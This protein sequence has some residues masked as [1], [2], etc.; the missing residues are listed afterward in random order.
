MR[1]PGWARCFNC[2]PPVIP[3][4]HPSFPRSLS[5]TP[6]PTPTPIGERESIPPRTRLSREACPRPRSG[7]R[8]SIPPHTRLSRESGNPYVLNVGL[9][10]DKPK[11]HGKTGVVAK[12]KGRWLAGEG[13][14][15]LRCAEPL[16]R[17]RP[18]RLG[19]VVVSELRLSAG[20]QSRFNEAVLLCNSQAWQAKL[21]GLWLWGV[22][23]PLFH[24]IAW[25]RARSGRRGNQEQRI[26]IALDS[27]PTRF[28]WVCLAGP[29]G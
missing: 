22:R 10:L 13:L 19:R 6:T 24:G 9:P 18:T 12:T 27:G 15:R 1:V 7:E 20:Q 23:K 29:Q 28:L 21:S 14:R 16:V 8:E 11:V 2:L 4:A 26:G 17:I 3:A 5:P 25:G